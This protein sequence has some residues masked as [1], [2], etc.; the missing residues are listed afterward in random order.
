MYTRFSRII[1]LLALL[2]FAV[3]GFAAVQSR[4]IDYKDG[5]T[6]L[7]GYLFWDDAVDGKRPGVLVVHEWWGLND[8]AKSRARQ[9]AELGYVAFALDMYGVD[10]V[11]KHPDEAGAWMKTVNANIDGWV[12]RAAAG[13]AVLKRQTGVDTDRVAAIG[14]CFGGATV[15]QMAYAGLGVNG[16]VSFHGA[17]Q[18][19]SDEQTGKIKARILIAHGDAD[20]FATDEQ[21]DSV[22]AALDHAGADW[23]ML[24]LGG[25]KHSFTNPGAAA[26]GMDALAYNANADKR[27]WEAMLQMFDDLFGTP[28]ARET[29]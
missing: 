12:K 11:T 29:R 24:I 28:P 14:Y 25:A 21:I 5:D 27:S 17:L 18:M 26:Y 15:L 23:D 10:K 16:V 7:R 4:A 2:A 19:P 8:Y 1:T 22:R 6:A 9:L 13:L 20:P 3:P